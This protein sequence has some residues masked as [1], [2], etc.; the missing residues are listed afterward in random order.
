MDMT[1]G[2]CSFSSDFRNPSVVSETWTII[3][4]RISGSRYKCTWYWRQNPP[5]SSGIRGWYRDGAVIDG[6]WCRRHTERHGTTKCSAR[7]Y[8]GSE[9]DGD[10]HK[11]RKADQKSSNTQILT[12][13]GKLTRKIQMPRFLC[14]GWFRCYSVVELT[15]SHRNLNQ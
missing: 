11:G 4:L 6:P 2:R 5:V 8:K 14:E 3:L 10:T 13:V 15:N 12:K 7:R 9:Y 1:R